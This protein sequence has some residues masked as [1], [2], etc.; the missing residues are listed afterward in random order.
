VSVI[1]A[2]LYSTC[3][4]HA[5]NCDTYSV[6]YTHISMCVMPV[7]ARAL[8]CVMYISDMCGKRMFECVVHMCAGPQV[9]SFLPD[10]VHVNI[11]VANV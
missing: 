9:D 10:Y 6:C 3:T 5:G 8:I 2:M 7:V 11:I 1:Y 4:V